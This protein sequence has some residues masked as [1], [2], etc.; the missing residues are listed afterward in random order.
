[1]QLFKKFITFT[2]IVSLFGRQIQAQELETP[3]VDDS[4]A[5]Y[6]SGRASYYSAAIPLAALAIAAVIIATSNRH[7]HHHSSS[8]NGNNGNS[9]GN[10]SNAHI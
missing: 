4:Y 2:A 10:V 8:G 6:D 5:Y 3:V 7:H 9:G 1:M